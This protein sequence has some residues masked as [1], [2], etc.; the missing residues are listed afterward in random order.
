LNHILD[1]ACPDTGEDFEVVYEVFGNDGHGVVVEPFWLLFQ[2]GVDVG[3]QP[4][5]H[6]IP[7][8]LLPFVFIVFEVNMLILVVLI[9]GE[10]FL[11]VP[12]RSLCAEEH[13]AVSF[14][15]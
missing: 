4:G 7:D 3:V 2:S 9:V 12:V 8:R 11:D 5:L 14:L 15:H 1:V 10:I 13:F 6:I